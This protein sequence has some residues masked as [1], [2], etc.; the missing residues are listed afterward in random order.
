MRPPQAGARLAQQAA[1]QQ[2]AVAPRLRRVDQ[3]EVEVAEQPPVLE[4][5][6]QHEQFTFQLLNGGLGQRDAV[7]PLQMRHVGQVFFQDQR[8]VVRPTLGAIAAA[9]DGH[10][11]VAAAVEAGHVF[12]ERRLAGA[13]DGEVADADDR[14]HDAVRAEPAAV[15]AEVAEADGDAV[16]DAGGGQAEALQGGAETAGLAA[17]DGEVT[18]ASIGGGIRCGSV[19]CRQ[20]DPSLRAA[21][22]DRR[23]P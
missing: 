22:V 20:R 11:H 14:P 7:F 17:D 9:E 18:P 15:V 3:H 23:H 5:V 21:L 2:P 12:H 6:V 13:A 4:P 1:R 8:L 16:G 10:A 19:G